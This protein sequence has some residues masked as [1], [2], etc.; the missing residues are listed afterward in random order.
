MT[1]A[2]IEKFKK[3]NCKNCKKDINC[4]IVQNIEGKLVCT[5]ED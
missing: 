4:K 5:E 3:E 1:V 2:E